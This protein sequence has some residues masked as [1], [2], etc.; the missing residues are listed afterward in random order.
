MSAS[1]QSGVIVMT[2]EHKVALDLT[3]PSDTSFPSQFVSHTSQ[4]RPPSPEHPT[5]SLTLSA[6]SLIH[7]TPA[8]IAVAINSGL[9]SLLDSN[10]GAS[11]HARDGQLTLE[12]TL[13][14]GASSSVN[15]DRCSIAV[16]CVVAVRRPFNLSTPEMVGAMLCFFFRLKRLCSTCLAAA[17]CIALKVTSPSASCSDS[18]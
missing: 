17:T 9:P 15:L 14:T 6:T 5:S 10:P 11:Y 3:A 13:R 4:T 1:L 8:T 12:R 18:F 2:P 7:A 16:C